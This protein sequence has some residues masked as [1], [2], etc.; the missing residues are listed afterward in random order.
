MGYLTWRAANRL[1]SQPKKY[2][3][4]NKAEKR[5]R[6]EDLFDIRHEDAE[7]GVCPAGFSP[8]LV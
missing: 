5:W 2:V 6:S 3:A 4:V 8:A 7:F 1:W